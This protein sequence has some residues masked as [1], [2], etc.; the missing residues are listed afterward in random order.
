M[1]KAV[2]VV[3]SLLVN[4]ATVGDCIGN[5]CFPVDGVPKSTPWPYIVMTRQSDRGEGSL[6]GDGSDERI[7]TIQLEIVSRTYAD[8]AAI[9]D[10]I[11]AAV[12]GGTRT[13]AGI[14][15]VESLADDGGDSPDG[16][17]DL[18]E[19]EAFVMTVTVNVAYIP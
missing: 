3:R 9:G 5:R 17:I 12:N 11:P 2:K 14:Q 19:S 1:S 18:D 8:A 6:N 10:A 4:D 13:V 16:P 15:V 7:A